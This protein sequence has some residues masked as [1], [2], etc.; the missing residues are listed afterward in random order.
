LLPFAFSPAI[1]PLTAYPLDRD[2]LPANIRFSYWTTEVI[3]LARAG[4]DDDVLL[5]FIDSVGT[6]NLSADEIIYLSDIGVSRQVMATMIQHDFEVA[7][8]LRLVT[9][10]S[11]PSSMLFPFAAGSESTADASKQ[12]ANA[13]APTPPANSSIP[14]DATAPASGADTVITDRGDI[15]SDLAAFGFGTTDQAPSPSIAPAPG[16]ARSVPTRTSTLYAVR[17]PYP[18][19]VTPPIIIVPGVDRTPNVVLIRF[20]P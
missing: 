12:P 1:A 4:I 10:S 8:G 3:K 11:S 19:A 16:Q 7:A 13:P 14:A 2:G 6:F 17:Q 20:N 18:E 5:P 15:M 9:A